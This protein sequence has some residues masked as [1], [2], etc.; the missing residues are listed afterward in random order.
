MSIRTLAIKEDDIHYRIVMQE[1]ANKANK[2]WAHQEEVLG[3]SN[4]K[5]MNDWMRVNMPNRGKNS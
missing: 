1:T 5:E 3:F 2:Y 4:M